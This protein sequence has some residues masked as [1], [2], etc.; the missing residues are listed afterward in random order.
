MYLI[1]KQLW[2][3]R[4]PIDIIELLYQLHHVNSYVVKLF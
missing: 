3:E 1:E 2:K 4:G